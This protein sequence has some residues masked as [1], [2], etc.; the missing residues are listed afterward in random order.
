MAAPDFSKAAVAE[1]TCESV[2]VGD[3]RLL[4]WDL[5]CHQATEKNTGV[6][7]LGVFVRVQNGAYVAGFV[8]IENDSLLHQERFTA[9][10]DEDLARQLA[11]LHSHARDVIAHYEVGAVALKES[12]IRGGTREASIARRAEGTILAAAGTVRELRVSTWVGA[13]MSPHAG[14]PR[15]R[16]NVEVVAA[17]VEPLQPAPTSDEARQAAAAA[18]VAILA[19]A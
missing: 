13:S 17:L 16:P 2:A 10:P 6:K 5:R 1:M 4:G 12:E 9:P 7:T 8:V 18:R 3:H 14:F 11:D 19:A 15:R